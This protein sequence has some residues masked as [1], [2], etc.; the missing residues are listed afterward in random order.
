MQKPRDTPKVHMQLGDGGFAARYLLRLEGVT[1]GYDR[2]PLFRGLDLDLSRGD[3][4]AVRG[5]NGS[6]KSTLLKLVLGELGTGSGQ[7][8]DAPRRSASVIFRRSW[9][10]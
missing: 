4:M 3:R 8:M 7:S 5:P 6:G 2:E 1:F 10:A 9:K